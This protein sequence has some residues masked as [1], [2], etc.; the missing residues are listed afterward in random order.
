MLISGGI[1]AGNGTEL[2][3]R[4]VQL[5]GRLLEAS[6]PRRLQRKHANGIT[7]TWTLQARKIMALEKAVGLPLAAIL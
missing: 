6:S 4:S 2:D 3:G 7:K 5:A 1:R